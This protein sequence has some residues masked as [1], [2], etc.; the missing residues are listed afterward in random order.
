MKTS[1]NKR[2]DG[3][4]WL[5]LLCSLGLSSGAYAGRNTSVSAGSVSMPNSLLV[6]GVKQNAERGITGTVVDGHN[7]PLIGVTVRVK[8][9]NIGVVTDLDGH[10]TLKT[11]VQNPQLEF[12][13][14]GF[15][16]QTIAP[17]NRSKVDVTLV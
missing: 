8:G 10:Y 9:T 15:T 3:L 16:P 12:S 4:P 13:F 6:Q 14:I 2:Q 17:G 5:L 7:E 1:N 11:N